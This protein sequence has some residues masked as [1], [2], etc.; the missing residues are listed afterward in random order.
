[1]YKTIFIALYFFN[2]NM[3]PQI[4]THEF[5]TFEECSA[6]SDRVVRELKFWKEAGGKA[7]GSQQMPWLDWRIS[8]QYLRPE[9]RT[10]H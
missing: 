2:P 1:M 7:D 6:F 3:V 4:E 9:W 10:E 5:D 8:C